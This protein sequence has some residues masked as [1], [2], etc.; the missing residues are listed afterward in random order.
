MCDDA[1]LSAY[2]NFQFFFSSVKKMRI[3]IKYGETLSSSIALNENI[4][5]NNNNIV[6][7][8]RFD[9]VREYVLYKYM[10]YILFNDNIRSAEQFVNRIF[11]RR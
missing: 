9:H 5:N 7:V 2:Q 3:E 4:R 1:F 8:E 11:I 10:M 6:T